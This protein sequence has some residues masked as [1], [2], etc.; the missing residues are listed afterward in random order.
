MNNEDEDRC[1]WCDGGLAYCEIDG[2]H[3]PWCI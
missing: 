3:C 2:W 1:S